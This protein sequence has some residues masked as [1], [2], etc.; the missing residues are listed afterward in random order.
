MIIQTYLKLNRNDDTVFH[1]HVSMIELHFLKNMF[2]QT[3]NNTDSLRVLNRNDNPEH[4]LSTNNNTAN[5]EHVS[6]KESSI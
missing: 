1:Q 5:L 3:N 6:F 2:H 4:V